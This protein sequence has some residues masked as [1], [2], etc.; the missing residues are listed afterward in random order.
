MAFVRGMGNLFFGEC[1]ERCHQ[2]VCGAVDRTG[3]EECAASRIS[4]DIR[5]RTSF[6]VVGLYPEE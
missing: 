1:R 5:L 3:V 2:V 6:T 4:G